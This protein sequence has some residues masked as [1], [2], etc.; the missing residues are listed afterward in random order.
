MRKTLSAIIIGLTL[1]SNMAY[2]SS[3]KASFAWCSGTPEFQLSNV[4][5]DT[6]KLVFEMTDLWVQ[7]YQHGGGS[8]QYKGQKI[9]PC[10]ALNGSYNLPS[11]PHPEVHEYEWEI[12][13]LDKDGNT[14]GITKTKR[15][16]PEN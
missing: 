14:L 16:F 11:P 10:G 8:I 9:I 6:A 4:P 1:T 5:K 12:K 7:S 2:A 13:A 15:K 3:F